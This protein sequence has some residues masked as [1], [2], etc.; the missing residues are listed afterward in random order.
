MQNRILKVILW[1]FEVGKLK[2]DHAQMKGIFTFNPDFVKK[3]LDIAPLT[4]SIHKGYGKGENVEGVPMRRQNKF[5]G[6][7]T[8]IADSLP[9]SWGKK[10]MMAWM[11]EYGSENRSLTPLDYLAYMGK[12]GMGALEFEPDECPWKQNLDVN[13]DRMA[14]LADK[15]FAQREQIKFSEMDGWEMASLCSVG[16]SAGGMQPKA[17][18]ARNQD[19]GEIRSGQ[20]LHD[21]NWKYYLL[22]F[23]HSLLPQQSEVEMAYYR[24]ATDAGIDMMPSELL[25]FGGKSHFMTER[26]DRMGNEKIHLQTL[27]AMSPSADS[28]E[29]IVEVCDRLRLPYKE[30]EEVFRRMVFN[31]LAACTDDHNRNFSFMMSKDGRWH[32]TPAYDLTFAVSVGNG[33]VEGEEHELTVRGKRTGITEKDFLL[34]AQENDIKNAAKIIRQVKGVVAQAHLYLKES[35]VSHE[36]AKSIS[37]YLATNNMAET[38]MQDDG[39][40]ITDVQIYNGGKNIRCKINGVRQLGKRMS[41]EDGDRAF[42]IMDKNDDDAFESLADELAHKYFNKELAE[43]I[44]CNPKYKR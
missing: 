21:G 5:T 25:M 2:W 38:M 18:I 4:A 3:G 14:R 31:V 15:I 17:V 1:G 6:L 44:V 26:F 24:M 20:I 16:T 7:P 23:S 12:R 37:G 8:F 42:G 34:F 30:K 41:Q 35:G 13:L 19:T 28:Y 32:I 33:I 29:D 40:R 39:C 10:L 36:Y 9:D 43:S 22:K 27:G 11:A